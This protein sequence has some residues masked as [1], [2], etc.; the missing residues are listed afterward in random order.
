MKLRKEVLHVECIHD[1]LVFRTLERV[2]AETHKCVSTKLLK[3]ACKIFPYSRTGFCV[4]RSH[5]MMLLR[6]YFDVLYH[7]GRRETFR[8]CR[9]G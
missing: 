8:I 5:R 3:P 9:L 1:M 4:L 7:T 6:Y 2:I